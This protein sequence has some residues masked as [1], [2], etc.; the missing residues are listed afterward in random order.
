ML[1]YRKDLQ[2]PNLVL[3]PTQWWDTS[4]AEEKI[5]VDCTLLCLV[6]RPWPTNLLCLLLPQS[7]L[8]FFCYIVEGLPDLL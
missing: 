2:M 4:L 5:P 7:I 3:P 6:L 8:A 1:T